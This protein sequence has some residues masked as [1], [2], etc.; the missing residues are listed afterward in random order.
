V[1]AAQP[2]TAPS[3]ASYASIRVTATDLI[4]NKVSQTIE[5]AWATKRTER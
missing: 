5:K 4:G 3:D 1:C 2:P